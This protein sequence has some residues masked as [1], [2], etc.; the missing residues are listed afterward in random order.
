MPYSVLCVRLKRRPSGSS[1]SWPCHV[2][3]GA[4]LVCRN[5]SGTSARVSSASARHEGSG[6]R[7]GRREG[8]REGRDG[9]ARAQWLLVGLLT[10]AAEQTQSPTSRSPSPAVRTGVR[11]RAGER[12]S[13][14]TKHSGSASDAFVFAD[15]VFFQHYPNFV[16]TLSQKFELS[17]QRTKINKL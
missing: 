15:S 17:T 8:L 12:A 9:I 6:R 4:P 2:W 13:R 7:E 16:S 10:H 11:V 14:K 3:P 1:D 5:R